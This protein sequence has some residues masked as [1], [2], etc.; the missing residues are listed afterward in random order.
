MSWLKRHDVAVFLFLAFALAWWTW[1]LALGNPNPNTA[2]MLPWSPLIAAL[3]VLG[4]TQGRRGVAGLL[5]A[6]VRWRYSVWWYLLAVLAPLAAVLAVVFLNA[7]LGAPAPRLPA[8]SNL[9]SILVSFLFILV[10]QGPL[11]EEPGW[12]GFLLPRLMTNRSPVVASLIVGIIWASWHLPLLISDPSATRPPVQ[13]FIFVVSLSVVLSWLYLATRG[14]LLL[15]ILMHAA[16]NTFAAVFIG[17]QPAEY[18][19]RVWWLYAAIWVLF[20]LVV[21]RSPVMGARRAEQSI[22]AAAG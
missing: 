8:L 16:T 5:R 20:A 10:V 2:I 12:R 18:Y 3:I 15:V 22:E 6:I 21:L 19:G 9:P 14:G 1:P 13:Y 4:L 17:G 7:A 11:T